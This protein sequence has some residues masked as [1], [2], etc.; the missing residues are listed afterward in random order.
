MADPCFDAIKKELSEKTDDKG[1]PLV[2][3]ARLK[4]ILDDIEQIK[5]RAQT[6]AEYNETAQKYLDEQ[7]LERLEARKNGL[8]NELKLKDKFSFVKQDAFKGEPVEALKA[9]LDGT[10]RIAREGNL[11]IAK[12]MDV[13]ADRLYSALEQ[14]LEREDLLEIA[15]SKEMD[16]EIAIEMFEMTKTNGTPGKTKNEVAIKIAQVYNQINKLMFQTL[17]N[18]DAAIR[19]LEGRIARTT[20]DADLI[21]AA[22]YDAW[23]SKILEAIDIKETFGPMSLMP[24]KMEEVLSGVYEEITNGTYGNAT[25]SGGRRFFKFK[26]GKAWFQYNKDFG[27]KGL[28]ETIYGDIKS[29]S[30][31]AALIKHL[32]IEPQKQWEKLVREVEKGI[33]D[34]PAAM[35]NWENNKEQIGHVWKQLLGETERPGRSLGARAVNAANKVTDMSKLGGAIK[36]TITD[37]ATSGA[38]YRAVSGKNFLS[39]QLDSVKNFMSLLNP[40]EKKVWAKRLRMYSTDHIGEAFNRFGASGD[41]GPGYLS[42]AHRYFFKMNLMEQQTKLASLSGGRQHAIHLGD[43]SGLSYKELGSWSR[44][45]IMERYGIREADWD[46]IRQSAESFDGLKAITAESVEALPDEVFAKAIKEQKLLNMSPEKY[47]MEL[48]NKVAI[49]LS[50]NIDF[51]L[52]KPGA[53]DQAVVTRGTTIDEKMGMFL[54]LVGKFKAYPLTVAGTLSRV[55]LSNPNKV[56]RNIGEVVRGKG[57]DIQGLVGTMASMTALGYM[58]MVAGDIMLGQEPKDPFDKKTWLEAF[59]RG[60]S[61][62]LYGDVVLGEYQQNYKSLLKDLAGPVIGQADDVAKLWATA[63]HGKGPDD[64]GFF[65]R[66]EGTLDQALKLIGNNTPG[67][68]LFWFKGAFNYTIMKNF[69]P[70]SWEDLQERL[71]KQ[72]RGLL[73]SP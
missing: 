14:G 70:E 22:G 10:S 38:S 31:N 48:G 47:R 62:G 32:G 4:Q 69:M 24:T 11:S 56:A 73:F 17:K 52:N 59:I 18:S 6:K 43:I 23:K 29:V 33:K 21:R 41:A 20:H 66:R 61:G 50:D 40:D 9:L 2:S 63:I 26:D 45:N 55:A 72:G 25:G 34:D 57:G 5:A 12:E 49:Y 3:D 53:R 30:R 44:A 68:N 27:R 46:V 51:S 13:N 19:E 71:E 54:R 8:L 36:N 58:G 15:V 42:R 16:E 37:V 35:K 67:Q 7:R 1:R 65:E 64:A 60:G 39:A 28:L